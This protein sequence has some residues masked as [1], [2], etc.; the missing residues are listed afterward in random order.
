MIV[1]F[2]FHNYD[3]TIVIE[4]KGGNTQ[5]AIFSLAGSFVIQCMN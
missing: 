3:R 5:N 2:S 4:I 1:T